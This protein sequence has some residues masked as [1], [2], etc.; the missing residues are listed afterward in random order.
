MS[1]FQNLKKAF[2]TRGTSEVGGDEKQTKGPIR[3][4]ELAQ[5][6]IAI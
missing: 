3:S 1:I 4:C 6:R 2:R 5:E